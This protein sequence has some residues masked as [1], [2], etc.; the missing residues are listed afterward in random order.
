MRIIKN[1]Q[2]LQ[3]QSDNYIKNELSNVA[4]AIQASQVLVDWWDIDPDL[5]Q[6]HGGL[7]NMEDFIGPESTAAYHIIDGL[8]MS[9]IDNPLMG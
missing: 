8:P 5:S 9:V 7:K 1:Q 6:T 3:R 2:I 4:T